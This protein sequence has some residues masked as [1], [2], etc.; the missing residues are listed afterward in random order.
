MIRDLLRSSIIRQLLCVLLF[1]FISPKAHTQKPEAA[2]NGTTKIEILNADIMEKNDNIEIGLQR[3]LGNVRF[4]HK[5]VTMTCDSAYYYKL[6]NQVKALAEFILNRVIHSIC[7]VTIFFTMQRLRVLLLMVMWNL[8]IRR[9][10][11]IPTTL[12]YDVKNKIA[13]YNNHGRIINADNT[14]TS[15]IGV[16]YASR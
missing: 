9:H 8:L 7:M 12:N 6:K 10:I 3:L 1:L 13:H 16:Y 4:R 15:I 5:E 11:S 2:G 14:L